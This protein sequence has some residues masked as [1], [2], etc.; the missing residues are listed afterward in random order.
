[1]TAP[2][3]RMKT[4][5]DRRHTRNLRELRLVVPDARSPAV[6]RRVAAEVALLN[7]AD[8]NEALAW[9]ETVAEFDELDNARDEAR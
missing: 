3:E 8:E 9:I 2:A 7:R 5:R 1:M 4:M 6:R